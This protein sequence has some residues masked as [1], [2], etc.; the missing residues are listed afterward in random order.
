LA[1]MDFFNFVADSF[2]MHKNFRSKGE[3]LIYLKNYLLELHRQ[4]RQALLIIDECQHLNQKLL[5]EVRLLSNI[6]KYNT[7]LINIF[8]VGQNEFNEIILRPRNRA[9]RQRITINYNIEA[10]SESETEDYIRFR[11]RVAGST[12]PIFTSQAIRSVYSFSNGYPRLINII[13]DQALLT[14]YVREKRRIDEKMVAECADEL[15]I[16]KGIPISQSNATPEAIAAPVSP[17]SKEKVTRDAPP[18]ATSALNRPLV[19]A[20]IVVLMIWSGLVVAYFYTQEGPAVTSGDV[21][22][23]DGGVKA[24]TGAP[25]RN[26]ASSTARHDLP[27]Q[28]ATPD[29]ADDRTGAADTVPLQP[30]ASSPV[31]TDA[32]DSV[33]TDSTD[34]AAAAASGAPDRLA[35]ENAESASPADRVTLAMIEKRYGMSPEVYFGFNANTFENEAYPLLQMLARYCLQHPNARLILRGYSDNSGVRAYNLKLSEFRADIV[36][37]YLIGRGVP[38]AAIQTIAMGPVASGSASATDR[39]RKVVIEIV[40]PE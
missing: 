6:E 1:K 20:L 15:K 30:S 23:A 9:I 16:S 29:A 19:I 34:P 38:A 8:F 40:A 28:P 22:I 36:K 27:T 18:L 4:N 13:C 24:R 3:F 14:G 21:S 2:E 26:A 35:P 7:K 33:T 25:S 32:T 39:M 5:E 37:T 17:A 12:E 11:L 10:L 31:Q